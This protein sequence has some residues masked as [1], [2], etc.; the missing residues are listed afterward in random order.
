MPAS[1]LSAKVGRPVHMFASVG[2]VQEP[3][4]PVPRERRGRCADPVHALERLRYACPDR[5]R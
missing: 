1:T 5:A 4:L 2:D 3:P